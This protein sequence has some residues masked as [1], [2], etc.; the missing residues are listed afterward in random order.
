MSANERRFLAV[1]AH[2][3]Y[4]VVGGRNQSQEI[5]LPAQR[6]DLAQFP[7]WA[8]E[9]FQDSDVVVLE[10]TGGAWYLYDLLQPLVAL[11][12]VAHPGRVRLIAQ[13]SVMTDQKAVEI[14]S[15]LLVAGIVPEVWPPP[16]HVRELRALVKH[17]QR[18][19]AQCSAAKNRLRSLLQR[20]HLVPPEGDIFGP[21]QRDWWAD[22]PLSECENLMT[23]Q[24]LELVEQTRRLIQQAEAKLA[25]LSMSQHWIEQSAFLIQIPGIGLLSAMTI[26][27]AVGDIR[28]FFASKNLVGYA[29][30]GARVHFSGQTQRRGGITKQGRTELRT[31]MI[32]VAWTAVRHH[33]HWREQFER[34]EQRIGKNKAIV[35][36]ARKL[37]VVVWPVLSE[38]VADR[39]ADPQIVAR[40]L[41]NWGS[42][43]RLATSLGLSRPQFVRQELDRLGIGL[44]LVQFEYNGRICKLPPSAL[45]LDLPAEMVVDLA[46]ALEEVLN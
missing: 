15:F 4:V 14:L 21:S 29:G 2:K 44:Q 24:N 28:R 23:Q 35:A 37:L 20:H 17:R 5:V 10:A 45:T 46:E 18:L 3:S 19:V 40:Y 25:A 38:Q 9:H 13:S 32:Q 43:H 36:I 33:A 39:R 6:V 31:V 8:Q 16:V 26:L 1:D 41:M 11:V 27:A 34:L 30:L 7:A 12:V 42:K 22:L